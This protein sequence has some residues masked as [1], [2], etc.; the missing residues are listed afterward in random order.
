[1]E[2]T[3]LFN[4]LPFSEGFTIKEALM[5]LMAAFYIYA[6]YSHFKKAWFFYK[7]TPPLLQKWKKPINVIVGMAEIAGGIG[8]LIPQTRVAAAWGIILLLIAVFP[9]NI[10]MLTS[11]GAGMKIKMWFLWL[12]LPLQLVFL[13]WAWW[14]T[15]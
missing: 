10:Y 9:A 12:R 11:K 15:K 7:I 2:Q 13:A 3:L 14:Y 8:L 5:Y 6:G 1:M 4:G